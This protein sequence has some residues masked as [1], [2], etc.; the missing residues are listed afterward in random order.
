[1][2]MI[3]S[4]LIYRTERFTV[5]M[6]L[7]SAVYILNSDERSAS[8]TTQHPGVS[9]KYSSKVEIMQNSPQILSENGVTSKQFQ[10]NVTGELL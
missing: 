5:A 7:G 10:L 9:N 6:E 1:M 4:F 8:N 3:K 2:E